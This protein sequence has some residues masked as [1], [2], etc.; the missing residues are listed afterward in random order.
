MLTTLLHLIHTSITFYFN[1]CIKYTHRHS[2]LYLK[3][4]QDTFSTKVIA[5]SPFTRS[6]S[7]RRT[8]I[9]CSCRCPSP[10]WQLL[11]DRWLSRDKLMQVISHDKFYLDSKRYNQMS[12]TTSKHSRG[13]RRK[14]VRPSSSALYLYLHT[15]A[16]NFN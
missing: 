9:N 11:V 10:H 8:D 2:R 6:L 12:H 14:E 3:T 16:L 7:I 5:S 4:Y 13:W 15:G 1:S